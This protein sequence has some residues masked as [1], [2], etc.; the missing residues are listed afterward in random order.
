MDDNDIQLPFPNPDGTQADSQTVKELITECEDRVKNVSL[1]YWAQAQY[2]ERMCVGDQ[3]QVLTNTW[4]IGDDTSWP[5]KIPFNA[6]NY[7]RNLE[8]TWS[9][10]ILEDRPNLKCY[11][12]EPGSDLIRAQQCDKILE[13]VRQNQDW[14]DLCFSAANLVQTHSCVA[15]KTVWDPLYGPASQG[16]PVYDEATGI[17][18]IDPQT[19]LQV[20]ERVGEPLGDVRWEVVS[21]FDYGTDGS[22]NVEDSKWVYFI[23]YIDK[24]DAE[25]L[26]RTAGINEPLSTTKYM[27]N[28]GVEKEG[29]KVVE[30][31]WRPDYRFP[32]G[33]Y[34]I[35]VG[36]YA[37]Q[38]IPFPYGHKE[39]PIAVWK[40]GP[41][42][43]SPYGSTHV[44]DAVYIQRTINEIV[45]AMSRQ[46]RQIR[47]VKLIGPSSVIDAI[48]EGNHMIKC[49]SVELINATRYLECPDMARVLV[50][51][52]E[53]NVKALFAIFGLNEML[54][55]AE[56]AK[57]GTAAKSI[58]Y[59]NKLDSMKMAG[60]SRSLSKAILRTMRQTLKLYQQYVKAPRIAHITG[61]NNLYSALLF[62]SADISGVDVR[63][64][65]ISGFSNMRATMVE[66]ANTQMQQVGPT[67]DLMSQAKTGL[68]QTAFDKSQREVVQAEIQ[69]ILQGQPVEPDSTIDGNIAADE[70]MGIISNYRGTPY[71]AALK[72][73]LMTYMQASQSQAQQPQDM[74]QEGSEL[75]GQ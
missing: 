60:A 25:Q 16:I 53:D 46:A 58:A 64:E 43:G 66:N 15:I 17:P 7:L 56:S 19:G 9:S 22:E 8:L 18:Q 65:P 67:P 12:S 37:L 72:Q 45:A 6:R 27:D 55:G 39:L 10:R 73:L 63:I 29:V 1:K 20:R 3:E 74:Q 31:W 52:L 47:D 11:P 34:A 32:D 41:R 57:S 50:T 49:D 59:L 70:I 62:T 40:C 28:W 14:D 68:P 26:V 42:R 2:N 13:Y 21:I 48:E 33:L 69:A 35:T 71:E 44:D 61:D 38:A 36:D 54:T 24:F 23:K 5:D 30:L 4:Q 51:S 75:N